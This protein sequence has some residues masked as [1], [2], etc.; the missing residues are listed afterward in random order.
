[1]FEQYN[2]LMTVEEVAKELDI[3]P[4][5]VRNMIQRGDIFA[6]KVCNRYRIPRKKLL[7]LLG[8]SA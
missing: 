3:T 4:L 8:L 5:T 2:E 7:E 1:M 6:I